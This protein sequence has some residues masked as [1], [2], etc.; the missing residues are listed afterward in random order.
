MYNF[1]T[2]RIRIRFIACDL[3]PT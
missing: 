2:Y 3:D 1:L